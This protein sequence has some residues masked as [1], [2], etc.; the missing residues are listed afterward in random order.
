MSPTDDGAVLTDIDQRF[1]GAALRY[2]RRHL[3]RTGTNPS[4]ATLI[5]ADDGNGPAIV[6]RGVTALG[7]RPH[8]EAFAL[9]EAG[10][11]ARGATA[12]VTLEPCAHHGRT[13]PCA[14]ALVTAGVARVVCAVSDPDDR[15]AGK[16]YQILRDGGITVLADCAPEAARPVL[17]AY[18]NRS[19]NKRAQVILKLAVSADGMIG[20]SGAGQVA[21]TSEISRAQTHMM[22]AEHDAI[23]VGIGTVLEDDP[24][25][26][27]RLEGMEERSPRRIVLDSHARLPLT[28][29][30]VK[31]ATFPPVHIATIDPQGERARTLASHGVRIIASE[32]HDGRIALPELLEDL[33]ALGVASVMVEGGATVARAFLEEGLVETIAL[34]ES[35]VIVGEGGVRAPFNSARL[36]DGFGVARTARYGDDRFFEL[37]RAV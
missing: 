19:A 25:L 17:G 8:A 32:D 14:D 13:P 12:Y 37:Q 29:K 15:V 5:V 23:L 22:R 33:A 36:P 35:S 28:S 27:C 2:G 18:L 6:G 20:R 34:Y 4:V 26:T 7:G 3:G 1:L 9:E 21:I 16:G 11:A 30:L 24:D 10:A 31:G